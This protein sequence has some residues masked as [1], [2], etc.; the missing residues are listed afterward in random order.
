[1]N[2]IIIT[3]IFLLA[4]LPANEIYKQ[5]RIYSDTEETLSILQTSG[6]DIDHSYREP[7]QWIEFAVSDSRIHLLDETQ[8]HYEIIHEDLEQF[9]ASRLDSNYESRDF[10]LGSMGGYYTFAEIEYHLDKLYGDFPELITEKVSLGQ[11]LEGRELWMEKV[12]D[13][14]EEDLSLIHI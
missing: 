11:T 6:L 5:V 7:G 10:E 12:S 4:F 2:N 9:Y 8:L 14:Q 13:N 3:I 1:M